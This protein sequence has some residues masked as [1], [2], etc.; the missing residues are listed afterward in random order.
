MAGRKKLEPTVRSSSSI[1]PPTNSAGKASKARTVA[2]KMPHTASGMRMRV[3][4]LVRSCS[5]V[6]T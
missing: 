4:P 3:M 5:T 1:T 6:V 2:T